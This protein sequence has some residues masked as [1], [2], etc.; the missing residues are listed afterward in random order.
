[1]HRILIGAVLGLLAA[2]VAFSQNTGGAQ[3]QQPKPPQRPAGSG[4]QAPG[5]VNKVNFIN[6]QVVSTDT[7]AGTIT[8]RTGKGAD[9]REQTFKVN[10]DTRFM[11]LDLK[12]LND[13][14][15]AEGF[16]TGADVWF[17]PGT[18]DLNTTLAQISLANPMSRAPGSPPPS[19]VPVASP[20]PGVGPRIP[21]KYLVGRVV[22]VD[23]DGRT[24]VIKTGEGEQAKEQTLRVPSDASFFGVDREPIQEGLKYEGLKPGATV[25]LRVGT[26]E[27]ANTVRE[28]SLHDPIKKEK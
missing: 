25:W 17:V 8:V 22:S 7:A 10:A 15:R 28:L 9:V 20:E 23:A 14:L 26:G 1:M 6:G 12:P 16:R 4:G 19:G 18:R 3:P 13:G 2:T 21:S 24:M 5:T 11:G 27:L